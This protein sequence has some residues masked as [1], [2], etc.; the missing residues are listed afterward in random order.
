MSFSQN[1][2]S[3]SLKPSPTLSCPPA[4]SVVDT[5]QNTDMVL[6]L[7]IA[8]YMAAQQ[9]PHYAKGDFKLWLCKF[10]NHCTLFRVPDNEKLLT[11]SQFL[12][13]E[14]AKWH[15]NLLYKDWEDWRKAAIKQFVPR[16]A[17]PLTQLCSIKLSLYNSF[18]EFITAFHRLV[19]CTLDE[20]NVDLNDDKAEAATSRFDKY[21]GILF[22]Q[23]ALPAI[24]ARFLCQEGP[25][26]LEDA[27]DRILTQYQDCVEDE[28]DENEREKSEWNLFCKKKPIKEVK[29]ESSSLLEE[30]AVLKSFLVQ[31]TLGRPLHV[32]TVRSLATLQ[33][34]S[35]SNGVGIAAWK[36]TTPA[37][38][39]LHALHVSSQR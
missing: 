21:Y 4:T 14:A 38:N 3:P 20:Q 35:Q 2:V 8:R 13:V 39:V 34:T 36:R 1:P 31:H 23:D 19:K 25:N 32:T 10:K 6:P 27:Y 17:K 12:D 11:V 33:Q 9:L 5:P 26:N 28:P 7:L 15:D 18:P 30:I 16:E 37:T 24:Y 22:L 29:V